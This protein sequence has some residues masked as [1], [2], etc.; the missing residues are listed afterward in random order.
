MSGIFTPR[1]AAYVG[2]LA[3]QA[4]LMP[5]PPLFLRHDRSRRQFDCRRVRDLRSQLEGIAVSATKVTTKK[6][7]AAQREAA[8]PVSL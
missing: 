8:R 1:G 6:R 7:Q 4:G 3:L 2:D 5:L